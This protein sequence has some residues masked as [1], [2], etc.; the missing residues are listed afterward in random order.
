VRT[1]SSAYQFLTI[2][3]TKWP[4]NHCKL[5]NNSS[6]LTYQQMEAW[7]WLLQFSK[8]IKCRGFLSI[9]RRIMSFKFKDL[10]LNNSWDQFNIKWLS[11][12]SNL[13][14]KDLLCLQ[15]Q[16]YLHSTLSTCKD[17]LQYTIWEWRSKPLFQG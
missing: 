13:Q 11:R 4:S 17:L 9:S 7:I 12:R 10:S 3:A 1:N 16:M 8:L 2:I 14:T 15:L 6:Q 5:P